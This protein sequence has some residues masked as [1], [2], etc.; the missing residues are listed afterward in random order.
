M[1]LIV[2]KKIKTIIHYFIMFV[3]F[4]LLIWLAELFLG[5]I[6]GLEL[7]RSERARFISE[8]APLLISANHLITNLD[9]TFINEQRSDTN[10]RKFRTDSYGL[11]KGGVSEDDDINSLRILFLGGST[12]ENNEVE[13][14]FRF[15]YLT[16]ERISMLTNFKVA[17]VNA[18]VRGHTTQDSINL[19]LN[20]P[21][22]LI[23]SSN[24]VVMMHNINDRLRLSI[25][26]SYK[27]GGCLETSESPH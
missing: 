12:T 14:Q 3:F 25:D 27:C 15:P 20:H 6:N 11:V 13:E 18:G 9:H 22:P 21:S 7:K 1:I 10:S 2:D 16:G 5:K 8:T 17:G 26:D 19:Y 23:K 4:M 24:V